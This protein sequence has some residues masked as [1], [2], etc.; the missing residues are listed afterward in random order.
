MQTKN[1]PRRTITYHNQ[2]PTRNE[3]MKQSPSRKL[4]TITDNKP[5]FDRKSNSIIAESG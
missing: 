5:E 4:T 1:S 3:T 2:S